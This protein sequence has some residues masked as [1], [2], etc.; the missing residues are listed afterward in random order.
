MICENLHKLFA[1][2][3]FEIISRNVY[4]NKYLDVAGR[5]E[6]GR[7]ILQSVIMDVAED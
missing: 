5:G 6:G 3:T 2:D 4:R 1:N 7:F